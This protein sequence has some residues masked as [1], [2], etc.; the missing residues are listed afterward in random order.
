MAIRIQEMK[1]RL[2]D[3][4]MLACSQTVYLLKEMLIGYEVLFDIFGAF[5]PTDQ[6]VMVDGRDQWRVWINSDF[7]SN[8]KEKMEC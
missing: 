3:V 5:E 7:T 2:K 4:R 1:L 8:V 6:M